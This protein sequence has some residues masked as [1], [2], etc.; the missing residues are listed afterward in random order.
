MQNDWWT[1]LAER[2]QRYANT[3]DMRTRTHTHTNTYTRTH[4]QTHTRTHADIHTHARTHA[5][6]YTPVSYTHL[7]LPTNAE[8]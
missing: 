7:T 4:T 5:H 2:T 3:G 1:A 8:V 6:A